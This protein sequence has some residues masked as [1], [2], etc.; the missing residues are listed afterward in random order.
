MNFIKLRS[1]RFSIGP[2]TGG[3]ITSNNKV[4]KKI[5]FTAVSTTKVRVLANATVDGWSR[6]AELEAWGD[7]TPTNVALSSNGATATASSTYSPSSGSGYSAVAANAINGDRTGRVSSATSWWNDGTQNSG[8]DWLQVD[9][10]GSK[11]IGE[12]D[13]FTAQDNYTSPS[14]PTET[15]T[16]SAYGLTGYDVQ[17]WDG[18]AWTTVSG[19]SITSNNKV[20]KKL[21]FSPITTSKIRVLANATADG[22]SRIT[23]VEAWT[24]S[25]GVSPTANINWLVTDQLGTPRL[26]F[27]QTGSLATTKRHDYLPFGE[28]LFNG[29]RTSGMGYAANDTTRQKFTSKERDNETGLD[30]F[31]ERYYASALG[32][33][34]TVDPLGS[35]AKRIDP[36]TMNRYTYALNNPLRYVDPDGL[37]SWDELSKR[38]RELIQQKLVLGKG[39]TVRD[40][41]NQLVGV[42]GDSN[43]TAANVE[44][45]KALIGA[46]GQ[47]EAWQQVK[48]VERVDTN[49]AN[50]TGGA[51]SSTIGMNVDRPAF[52]EA[53]GNQ[54]YAVNSL[55][56]EGR[57]AGQEI[58]RNPLAVVLNVIVGIPAPSINPPDHPY[59]NAR[60][61]T[62]LENE[63][64]L[65]FYNEQA[66]NYFQAHWDRTSSNASTQGPIGHLSGAMDHG[67]PA[68]V[69]Q[70]NNYLKKTQ[71]TPQ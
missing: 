43:A 2:I 11:T 71:K 63:P 9:F 23:E 56:E 22:W 28:E 49:G 5:T 68:T 39:Q 6:V 4:W 16:F 30:Y 62:T 65:H 44:S 53:L 61:S 69:Q 48:S 37:D 70:V 52:L 32:R 57:K 24:A 29:A 42:K 25:S 64:Q 15:M 36:Q 27:D 67:A 54:G 55:A 14:A 3:S 10:S 41:F 34:T 40:R 21:T 51:Y 47:T 1:A 59:D 13:V 50:S 8:P 58:A 17:Y 45:V 12:I 31:G 20:W 18:S 38:E 26:I 35:S 19:G 66:G 7:D 60:A 46:I 33:F